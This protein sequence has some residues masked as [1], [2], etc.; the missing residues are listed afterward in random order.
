MLSRPAKSDVDR[1]KFINGR[2][3]T[4]PKVTGSTIEIASILVQV[5]PDRLSNVAQAIAELPGTEIYSR[6]PKG[7]LVVVVE[8][9]DVGGIGDIL[10]AI[11]LLP[12][13]LTAALV[14]HGSDDD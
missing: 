14:F 8:A 1:R 5:R 11:S 12:N 2:W 9:A 6:S 13:V 7:K 4:T 10:N 3:T